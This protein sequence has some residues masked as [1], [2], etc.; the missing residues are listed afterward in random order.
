MTRGERGTG[1]YGGEPWSGQVGLDVNVSE[2]FG[3]GEAQLTEGRVL[4]AP[5]QIQHFER[6]GQTEHDLK[7]SFGSGISTEAAGREKVENQRE[8]H[9]ALSR[10]VRFW[11]RGKEHK[12]KINA[13]INT[14]ERSTSHR[15]KVLRTRAVVRHT[16]SDQ[17]MQTCSRRTLSRMM[18]FSA[19]PTFWIGRV[20]K[21]RERP[22][23]I[24]HVVD[25]RDEPE[26]FVLENLQNQ[27]LVLWE[28]MVVAL[29]GLS[30]QGSE[31]LAEER[32]KNQN[33]GLKRC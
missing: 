12:L 27:I 33:L 7:P 9:Q 13:H 15:A 5:D 30:H 3:N 10:I 1:P 18:L 21:I 16:R 31:T 28:G 2:G 6:V 17:N 26:F 23:R 29:C 22:Y 25:H 24:S 32:M 11:R 4:L 20:A 19:S 8:Q 14:V